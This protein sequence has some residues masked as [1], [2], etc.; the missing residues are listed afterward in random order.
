MIYVQSTID[1]ASAHS[2]EFNAVMAKVVG[3]MEGHQG[4]K[5]TTAFVQITGRLSTYVDI[6]ELPDAATFEAGLKGLYAYP[7]FAHIAEVLGRAVVNETLVLGMPVP[8]MP[9]R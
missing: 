4:W 3:F 5:L 7:E 6:W 2:A 8:Y 9:V 1:V